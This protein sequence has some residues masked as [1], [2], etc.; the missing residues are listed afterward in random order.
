VNLLVRDIPENVVSALDAEAERLGLSRSEYL[1]RVLT[2]ATARTSRSVTVA[3]LAG[4]ED[5]F[6]DLAD[7]DVM[8]DGWRL[9]PGWSTSPR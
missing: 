4:F 6:A 7:P 2:Q 5:T 9:R 8:D 1:R 3:E